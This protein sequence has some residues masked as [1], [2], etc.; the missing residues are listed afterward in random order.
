MGI[1]KSLKR[2]WQLLWSR[3]QPPVK[4]IISFWEKGGVDFN[5]YKAADNNAWLYAFLGC[6]QG[7]LSIA[8]TRRLLT[9]PTYIQKTEWE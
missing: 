6:G 9:L 3:K 8:S 2:R 7:V 4:C 1:L 5:Y